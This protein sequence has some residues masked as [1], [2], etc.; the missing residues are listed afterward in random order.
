MTYRT[1]AKMFLGFIALLTGPL[2][3]FLAPAKTYAQ[4]AGATLTGAVTDP[5]GAVLPGATVS[6]KNTA[7]GVIKNVTSDS[8]GLYSVPNLIP[9]PYSVTASA[10]GFST[11]VR[12]G[13]T[14]TVGRTQQL[15]LTLQVGAVSQQVSVTGAPPLVQT[16]SSTVSAQVSGTTVRQLPLNGRDWTLLATLQ[17]PCSPA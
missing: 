4:V 1:S 10:K 17:P 14:L 2:V 6:I 8:S 13:I 7:T 3:F 12:S 9:G 5:S 11:L 16:A 15:N